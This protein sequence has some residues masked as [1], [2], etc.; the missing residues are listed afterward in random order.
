M[1]LT[2]TPTQ[3]IIYMLKFAILYILISAVPILLIY[4]TDYILYVTG[5]ER[6][7]LIFLI[8][9]LLMPIILFC[10]NAVILNNKKNYQKLKR[11]Q[12]I[13]LSVIP[14]INNY[15]FSKRNKNQPRRKKLFHFIK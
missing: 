11:N 4:F 10:I 1:N 8:I 15:N 2:M 3:T 5:Y 7:P 14:S 12:E 6:V 13:Y 9:P